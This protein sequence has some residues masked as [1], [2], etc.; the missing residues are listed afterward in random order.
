MLGGLLVATALVGLFATATRG[1]SSGESYVVAKRPIV[2]GTRLQSADLTSARLQLSPLL[3]TRTFSR[4]AALV[5]SI[6]LAP[7]SP[8]ELVQ[9]GAVVRG[10]AEAPA[11]EESFTVERGRI[12]PG[13]AANERVDILATYGTGA[14]A[15]TTAVV[16]RARVVS[17]DRSRGG[18]ADGPTVVTVALETS[19]EALALAH[20]TALGKVTV[21]RA[22]GA[23]PASGEDDV[24]RP[25][26]KEDGR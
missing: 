15:F 6:A 26:E 7:L 4:E 3:R 20:A 2:A 25:V 1:S 24:Y 5:G 12:G 21:V 17:L 18:M 13:L 8:G 16:R 9:A 11:R 22:P 23:G 10:S 14:D 19:S